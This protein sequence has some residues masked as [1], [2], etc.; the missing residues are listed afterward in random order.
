MTLYHYTDAKGLQGILSSGLLKPS[1]TQNNPND[2]RYGEGQY[3]SDIIP[4]SKSSAQLSRLFVNNPFQGKKY[5]HYI[6]ILVDGLSIVK[7]R[8]NVYVIQS[9]DSLSLMGRIIDFGKVWTIS[10]MEYLKVK[11]IHQWEDEPAIIY[12]EI[13]SHRNEKRKIELFRNGQVGYAIGNT[14]RGGTRLSEGP[15]PTLQSIAADPQ[16]EPSNISKGEF[17]RMWKE[18]AVV[19]AM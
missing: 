18:K 15:L 5:T 1:L 4:G 14:E 3:L 8:K 13:D 12:S 19:I 2:V 6:E 9:Q 7:G 16:F 11:W 17:E 10:H